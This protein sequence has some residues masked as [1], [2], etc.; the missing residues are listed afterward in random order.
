MKFKLIIEYDGTGYAGWQSQEN[1]RTIQGTLR[2]AAGELAGREVEIQGAGRTD[3]GVHALGQ[4]AHLVW[5]G[6]I[7]PAELRRRLNDLLPHSINI[8]HV[9]A[10]PKSFHARHD[11]RRRVYVYVISR[12]RTAFGKRYVWWVKDHLRVE[13]MREACQRF[14]G[15]HDFSAFADKRMDKHLSRKVLLHRVRLEERGA[16][17]LITVEGSHFLWKMVRRMVGILVAVG[18]GDL[19]VEDV[20]R[21]LDGAVG[22]TARFTA[23]AS[24]LFLTRVIYGQDE[25][26]EEGFPLD[27][28]PGSLPHG[29]WENINILH[30]FS[31]RRRGDMPREDRL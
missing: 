3:A 18:R 29:R 24:G 10:V 22:D 21:M 2:A 1:A 14:E 11:A 9:E 13:A 30:R 7:E 17:V 20:V 26:P 6:R 31:D 5:P 19:Q 8:L 15:F 12:E 16:L 27:G 25:S 4:V 28:A 23:P